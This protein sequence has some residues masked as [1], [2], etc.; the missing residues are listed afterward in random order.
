MT[1]DDAGRR[2]AYQELYER[3]RRQ[4]LARISTGGF[5]YI[6]DRVDPQAQLARRIGAA[7][8][9]AG[10]TLYDRVAEDPLGGAM[11]M[12]RT[13]PAGGVYVGWTI[14][15]ALSRDESRPALRGHV[16]S[17]MNQAVR[18]VL[19]GY[20]FDIG[21]HDHPLL[22]TLGPD[23]ERALEEDLD[24]FGEHVIELCNQVRPGSRIPSDWPV[25]DQIAVALVL[26]ERW[27]IEEMGR[28][29]RD[30]ARELFEALNGPPADPIAWVEAMR[31][32]LALPTRSLWT[33]DS[34][35][36]PP[37]STLRHRAEAFVDFEPTDEELLAVWSD[38]EFAAEATIFGWNDEQVRDRLRTHLDAIA[39]QRAR[40]ADDQQDVPD[41][42]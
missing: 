9:E 4:Q 37:L 11:I 30:A 10:F 1:D 12:P 15:D 23:P 20:G 14:P 42:Q 34:I 16:S 35:A 3:H 8:V 28:T 36:G 7:L 31:T 5:K 26:L 13:D 25:L 27:H 6:H 19:E 29:P 32:V 17:I 2:R 38:E 39:A 40:G 41:Q 33:G 24:E 18:E 21:E 22:V